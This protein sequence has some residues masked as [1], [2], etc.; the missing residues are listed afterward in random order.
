MPHPFE[1]TMKVEG[2]SNVLVRGEFTDPEYETLLC[3]LDQYE[4]LAQS[5]PLKEGFPCGF[6]VKG[7]RGSNLEIETSLPDKDTLSILLH[8]LRP[9][10]LEK[11]HT[12]FVVVSSI[13]GRRVEDPHIRQL[14]RQQRAMYDGRQFQQMMRIE[15]NSVVVNSDQVLRDWLNSHEYHRDPDKR[16]AI[17]TLFNSFP[18]DFARGILISM[19][20]DKVRAIGNLASLAAVLLG[21]TSS[22]QFTAREAEPE[23]A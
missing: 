14:L 2:R 20:V 13:V 11:E 7:E 18:G 4:Q 17:D 23:S 12:S 8:R 9:F 6:H 22:F 3:Y 15:M 19:I 16:E 21:K 10:I 5:K 1:L